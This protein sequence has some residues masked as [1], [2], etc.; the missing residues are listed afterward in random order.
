MRMR[1]L[2]WSEWN[3][4]VGQR[5]IK[6]GSHQ[7]AI[8]PSFLDPR[9]QGHLPQALTPFIANRVGAHYEW[10]GGWIQKGSMAWKVQGSQYLDGLLVTLGPYLNRSPLHLLKALHSFHWSKCLW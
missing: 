4:G 10:T 5:N 6:I 7:A 8:L 3:R 9:A 1:V 2:A